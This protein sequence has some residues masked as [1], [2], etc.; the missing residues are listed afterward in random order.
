V[1]PVDS[2]ATRSRVTR[3]RADRGPAG[4][5]LDATGRTLWVASF[6]AN[7]LQ[8]FDP[9]SG[10]LLGRVRVGRKPLQV[11][12]DDAR[13]RVFVTNF[14]SRSVT[15]VGMGIA[16]WGYLHP[17]RRYM[18]RAQAGGSVQTAERA[19]IMLSA[20]PAS[21]RNGSSSTASRRARSV[22]NVPG[23]LTGGLT[24]SAGA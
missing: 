11:G 21:R 20:M 14:G 1:K 12:I 23:R 9:T 5:G 13:G 22:G 16:L 6:G 7:T 18:T 24:A 4:L 19:V 3:F 10:K 15:V 2:I 17:V 8:A